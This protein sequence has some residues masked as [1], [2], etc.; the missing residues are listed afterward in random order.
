MSLLLEDACRRVVSP[1]LDA[2]LRKWQALDIPSR[3][4]AVSEPPFEADIIP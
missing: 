4:T 2:I 3:R 1:L